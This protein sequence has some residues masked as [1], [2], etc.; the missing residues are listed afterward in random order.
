MDSSYTLLFKAIYMGLFTGMVIA[1]P[2]GPAGLES[3][4]WTLTTNLRK[5]LLVAA[6]SLIADAIDILFINFGLLDLFETNKLLEA[7]LWIVSGL[8]ILFIG[9]KAIRS[10]HKPES[11][12]G[13]DE[14][15]K[16]GA[17]PSKDGARPVLVGFIVNFTN[18]MTHFFW[19]TLS[20]TVI[21]VWKS[22]G[23]LPYFIYAVAMLS[24][25]FLSLAG[26]NLLASK[27]KRL[28]VPKL[29][30]KAAALLAYGVTAFG[31][32]FLIN[33]AYKLFLIFQ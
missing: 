15:Q 3:I 7:I 33:G 19:L 5:G 32:G 10:E 6:G 30:G 12:S 26:L 18:P 2:M 22:A 17:L 16:K 13:S 11:E 27:G 25:M 23:Q 4:R 24:G 29:S 21:R 20:S 9:I 8:V 1:I 28:K 31:A 14:H